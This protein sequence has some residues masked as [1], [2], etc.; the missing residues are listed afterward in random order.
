MNV[1]SIFAWTGIAT[2]SAVTLML[3]HNCSHAPIKHQSFPPVGE[4]IVLPPIQP[5]T[6]TK[7]DG[8][9]KHI[10]IYFSM[11]S[12][13]LAYEDKAV[14][15]LLSKD[16]RSVLAEFSAAELKTMYDSTDCPDQVSSYL[17][18]AYVGDALFCNNSID[19]SQV[20]EFQIVREG[21]RTKTATSYII[22][23]ARNELD[24]IAL[25]VDAN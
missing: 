18:N 21:K 9:Y 10:L 23:F 8:D 5:N 13:T 24:M 15:Q 25:T 12:A 22:E 4:Q 3:F 2:L 20:G 1:R 14:V 17:E 6:Q 7:A 16:D 11:G 19:L